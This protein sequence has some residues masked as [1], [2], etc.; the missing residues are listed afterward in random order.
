V[1]TTRERLGL[2][3][4][5]TL[6]AAASVGAALLLVRDYHPLGGLSPAFSADSAKAMAAVVAESLGVGND[7]FEVRAEFSQNPELIQQLYLRRGLEDGNRLLRDSIPGYSWRV[8]WLDR[9]RID[10]VTLGGGSDR[11]RSRRIAKA[12]EGPVEVQ[13]DM[14]GNLIAFR[15]AMTDTGHTR[16]LS[17][18]EA[19]ALA[20]G[21]V[22]RFAPGMAAQVAARAGTPDIQETRGSR[23]YGYRVAWTAVEPVLGDSVD[24]VVQL[25]G[26][27]PA[28]LEFEYRVP[29]PEGD[30]GKLYRELAYGILILLIAL[31]MII[32][33]VKRIRAYELGFRLGIGVG[34]FGALMLSVSA[35]T[36]S[37]PLFS[38][39]AAARLLIGPAAFGVALAVLWSVAES[40]GRERYREKFISLD[41]LTNGHLL[42]SRVGAGLVRG[43][44]GGLFLALLWLV[45]IFLVGKVFPVWFPLQGEEQGALLRQHGVE[46]WIISRGLWG[47]L[48]PLAAL[49]IFGLSVLKKWMPVPLLL[50]VGGMVLGLTLRSPV[51]P[52]PAGLLVDAV[53][54]AG[55]VALFLRFDVFTTYVAMVALAVA[56]GGLPL[57]FAADPEMVASGLRLVGFGG[58]GLAIGAVSLLTRDREVDLEAVTPA[59]SKHIT[60]RERLQQELEIA[61][62]VQKSLLPKAEPRF[63][64]LDIA[65]R[66]VPAAEVGGDYYDFVQ[67]SA[68]RLAVVVGDVSGKG[69]EGAFYMTLA[70]GFLKAVARA[71]ESPA[72]IL[73]Q[74]NSL[75]FENVDRGNF[76]SV[77]YGVFDRSARSVTIARA[78]HNPVIVVRARTLATEIIQPAGIALGLEPGEVFGR[79]IQEVCLPFAPGDLFVFY[80]DGF[81][82]A[83]NP[84]GDEYGQER[85]AALARELASGG[86]HDVLEGILAS[87]RT[88]V[89]RARQRDDM[90]MVVVKVLNV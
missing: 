82:E 66:C 24:A 11:E 17:P 40:I 47:S 78:G 19:Q 85:L 36:Q 84:Q 86:A 18:E 52:T 6:L 53:M 43:I 31:A 30:P 14:R 3:A 26:R 16:W 32:M 75:F 76:I 46:V 90:T 59:F 56:H 65:S 60:E 5:Y 2:A 80:T 68:D 37:M 83:A 10:R 29:E 57:L 38:F 8:S 13:Y 7:G 15:R 87:V 74:A 20:E 55:L 64:G 67:F 35:Y 23:G 22:R 1:K 9:S 33:A 69:T 70:K 81:G 62:T 39:E 79:T 77:V 4:V 58:V 42:H 89:G 45:A 27:E 49:V 72:K 25:A 50:V 44:G 34:V 41:L 28:S 61:R 54:A 48:L 73:E 12:L 88:F 71:S 51:S 63:A 21:I